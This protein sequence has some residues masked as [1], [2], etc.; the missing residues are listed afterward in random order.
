MENSE[1]S[2]Q[3]STE[4]NDN[5]SQKQGDRNQQ[6]GRWPPQG[7]QNQAQNRQAYPNSGGYGRPGYQMY[8]RGYQR[9]E[10]NNPS[11]PRF[12]AASNV[13]CYNCQ[14]SGHLLRNCPFP[15]RPVTGDGRLQ[16]RQPGFFGNQQSG[17]WGQ[18]RSSTPSSQ[19][20]PVPVT[21]SDVDET[22]LKQK[23]DPVNQ[24]G[25]SQ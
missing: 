15:P 5:Q 24:T 16:N 1:T 17:N 6:R 14:Q 8:N 19:P 13:V 12:Q 4:H 7:Q 23:Q 18:G 3:V 10:D 2:S 22:V 9:W 20:P 11:Q 21:T 25:P